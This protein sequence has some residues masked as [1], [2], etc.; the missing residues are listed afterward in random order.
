MPVVTPIRRFK[1]LLKSGG[2][3]PADLRL[4]KDM[5]LANI[6]STGDRRLKFTISTGSVDRDSD[7]LDPAGWD[8]SEYRQNPVVLWSHNADDFPIGKTVDVGVTDGALWAE[9]EFI[10]P[11]VPIAGPRAEAV[12]QMCTGGFLNAASVGFHP[13]DFEFSSDRMDDFGVDFRKQKLL[14]W[15]IVSIPANPEALIEP[16]QSNGTGMPVSAPEPAVDD[17]ASGTPKSVSRRSYQIRARA[18]SV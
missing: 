9:V 13:V 16:T 6:T 8:L 1:S 17:T 10:A 18:A 15:S 11:D 12:Y 7:V 3:V 5:P 4:R 14:E 2:S